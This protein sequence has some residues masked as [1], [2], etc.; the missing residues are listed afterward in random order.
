MRKRIGRAA[1][2]VAAAVSVAAG[3]AL[4]SGAAPAQTLGEALAQAYAT[5]PRLLS[6][7]AGLRAADED[8]A[9]ALAGWRPVIEAKSNFGHR[10]LKQDSTFSFPSPGD[11]S[12]EMVGDGGA[13]GA[14]TQQDG[15]SSSSSWRGTDPASVELS[16]SQ[17]VYP[18]GVTVAR[19]KAAEQRVMAARAGLVDVE[20]QVLADAAT[21][22]V[23]VVRDQSVVELNANNE[24]VL[25]R[26]LQATRDRFH[27]GEVTRTDV[28]QAEARVADARASS[29]EA[30][31]NLESAR[32]AYEKVVGAPPGRLSFPVIAAFDAPE[33]AAVALE[34][35]LVGNPA[36]LRA[37]ALESAAQRDIEVA[38]SALLPRVSI[39]ALARRAWDPNPFATLSDTAEII[40]NV[41]IPLYRSGEEYARLRQLRDVA[42]QRRREVDTARREVREGVARRWE[43]LQTAQARVTAFRASVEAN[44]I[45]LEG[46]EQEAAVG[47]RT[48]LDVL[49]A[50]QELFEARVNLVRAESRAATAT[51]QLLRVVGLMTAE[52]LGLPTELY[53]PVAHYQ[54]TRGKWFGV[55]GD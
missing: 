27:V 5:N 25:E 29:I 2:G 31:G 35:G 3:V 41:T 50:E 48:V 17:D 28:S 51:F 47:A 22:Y 16:V 4:A 33:S 1:G 7:R 12:T 21:A 45:A 53:D 38:R 15:G 37:A 11:A 43:E 44:D 49:D 13:A 34:R 10:Q 40:A 39:D 8:V 32:A 24:Q 18:F 52:S 6:E 54:E 30:E 55:G 9:T 19:T 42:T 36:I 20:Q 23:V 14:M 46:V 26:Q